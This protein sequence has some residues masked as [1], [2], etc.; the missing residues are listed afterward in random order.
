MKKLLS[1]LLI[2]TLLLA[3]CASNAPA[4]TATSTAELQV[5]FLDVGQADCVLLRYGDTDILID[6]GNVEDSSYVVSY[7]QKQG[8]EQLD[9]VVCSH[10]HE[11]HVGGLP[12]VLAVFPTA[13]VWSPTKT[14]SSKCF[15]D[16]VRYAD[17]QDL[18]IQIPKPGKTAT[19]GDLTLTVL[20]PVEDYAETNN[21]SIVIKAQL[22]ERSFLFTGDMEKDWTSAHG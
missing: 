7:L 10:A 2:L 17:Q 4:T 14:Y 18:E 12:G 21:T 1:L 15:D 22:K 3:G 5:H 20:G 11:D 13:E 6:G 9:L 19:F 16:F 8:V